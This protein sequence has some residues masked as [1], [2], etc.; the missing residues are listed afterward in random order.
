MSNVK[1]MTKPE[2]I[3]ALRD[4]DQSYV[5]LNIDLEKYDVD[6]LRFH[7][8]RKLDAPPLAKA[9]MQG[10]WYSNY[11]PAPHPAKRAVKDYEEEEVYVPVVR[12]VVESESVSLTGFDALQKKG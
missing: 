1:T 12:K 4:L 7:Y 8:Q 11:T 5:R 2:L 3:K 6:Q 10:G 9:K